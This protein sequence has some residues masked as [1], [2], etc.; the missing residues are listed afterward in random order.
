MT[1][2]SLWDDMRISIR[3]VCGRDTASTVKNSPSFLGNLSTPNRTACSQ[4]DILAIAWNW[5]EGGSISSSLGLTVR[6]AT[7][8]FAVV[9]PKLQSCCGKC[10]CRTPEFLL[11]LLVCFG[12]LRRLDLVRGDGPVTDGLDIDV[13]DDRARGY[14]VFKPARPYIHRLFNPNFC[15]TSPLS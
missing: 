12:Y 4:R 10:V 9:K 8:T 15:N 11:P 5:R 14:H 3:R 6:S 13:A 7:R 1:L 2:A